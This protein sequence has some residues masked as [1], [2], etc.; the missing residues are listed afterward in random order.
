[1]SHPRQRKSSTGRGW[2]TLGFLLVLSVMGVPGR[3]LASWPE[4]MSDEWYTAL[5]RKAPLQADAAAEVLYDGLVVGLKLDNRARPTT[6]TRHIRAVRIQ[7]KEGLEEALVSFAL[8]KGAR[9]VH[10]EAVTRHKDGTTQRQT[11]RRVVP[12]LTVPTGRRPSQ[13]RQ[14]RFAFRDV[15]VDDLIIYDITVKAPRDGF[16]GSHF[17]DDSLPIHRAELR[18]ESTDFEY[19][20]QAA[21]FKGE[22][23]TCDESWRGIKTCYVTFGLNNSLPVDHEPFMQQEA[24]APLGVVWS[25]TKAVI[26]GQHVPIFKTWQDLHYTTFNGLDTA[27]SEPARLPRPSAS[28]EAEEPVDRVV[29]LWQASQQVLDEREAF[30]SKLRTVRTTLANT[31]GNDYDRTLLLASLLEQESFRPTLLLVPASPWTLGKTAIPALLG[32]SALVI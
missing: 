10:F 18:L 21:T 1:M 7:Q 23:Q 31:Y 27:L 29:A 28:S 2:P 20:Y 17:L 6:S 8:P 25:V 11:E 14:L 30:G 3:S 9:I 32:L 4:L 16:S 26:Q 22:S 13:A 24:R 12:Y 19:A 5:A 15:R